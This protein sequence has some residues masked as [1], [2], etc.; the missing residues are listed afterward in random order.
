M[1][2]YSRMT[3]EGEKLWDMFSLS[4]DFGGGLEYF[5]TY[6]EVAEEVDGYF[7]LVVKALVVF[8]GH[9]NLFPQFGMIAGVD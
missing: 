4:K 5:L 9:L 6:F 2:M 3:L 1:Y 7:D 8:V